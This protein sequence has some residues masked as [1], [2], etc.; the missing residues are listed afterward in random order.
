MKHR[1]T[2]HTTHTLR[3]TMGKRLLDNRKRHTHTHTHDTP[4]R[5]P[6]TTIDKRLLTCVRNAPK[7]AAMPSKTRPALTVV[8]VPSTQSPGVTSRSRDPRGSHS[9]LPSSRGG[10]AIADLERPAV[11][12]LDEETMCRRRGVAPPAPGELPQDVRAHVR[13]G[14]GLAHGVAV[15][16]K[17]QEMR[18]RSLQILVFA[19][20]TS[21][22]GKEEHMR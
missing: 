13:T 15:E 21:R 6:P 20:F 3:G 9:S 4:P 19:C 11:K 7:P 14:D 17:F 16:V 18:E 12:V 8:T 22:R 1:V 2:R 5:F 10:G